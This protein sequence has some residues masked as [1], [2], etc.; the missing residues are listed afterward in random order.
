M[1][2]KHDLYNIQV[3]LHKYYE[4][5]TTPD[6]EKFIESFFSESDA[7]TL[8]YNLADDKKLFSSMAE[9]HTKLAEFEIPDSLIDKMNAIT[10]DSDD[11]THI[12]WNRHL[13]YGVVATCICLLAIGIKW[14]TTPYVDTS[15]LHKHVPVS[16]IQ[17]S[18]QL[19]S[20]VP[21]GK[22]VD[23][24]LKPSKRERLTEYSE[25]RKSNE[26]AKMPTS[27]TEADGYIEI[28]DPEEAEKIII[29]IGRLLT[30]NSKKTNEAILNLEKTVVEYKE[31]T[32]SILK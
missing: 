32:K 4:A 1:K 17:Q 21:N 30:D 19:S 14:M 10:E 29:E 9:L 12:K 18:A 15:Q 20:D 31:I 24:P 28:T 22:T 2:N 27:S 26:K 16:S 5:K 7:D 8:P 25:H 3:L 13:E 6:E 11:M 23:E